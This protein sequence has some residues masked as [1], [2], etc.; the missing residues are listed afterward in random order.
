MREHKAKNGSRIRVYGSYGE[1]MQ[2]CLGP[3]EMP[4]GKRSSRSNEDNWSGGSWAHAEK[5]GPMGDMATA[6]I[7]R[8]SIIKEANRVMG[9]VSR[10]DP[11]YREE[12]GVW[13]DVSRFLAGEPEVWGDMVDQ[14]ATRRARRAAIVF[15][16]CANC[17]VSST[18][19]EKVARLIGGA[20]LGLKAMGI[21]VSLHVCYANRG[22]VDVDITAIDMTPGEGFDVA[23]LAA[24]TSTWFFR[25]LVFSLWECRDAAYRNGHGI[26]GFYGSS[27]PMTQQ[28]AQELTGYKGATVLNLE[29]MTVW[30]EKQIQEAILS[31]I[32]QGE[33]VL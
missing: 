20:I 12:G 7:L 23:R 2:T 10:F 11:V 31:T 26:P 22:G 6:K 30:P 33:A 28:D 25:R 29:Q 21:S 3:S 13:I 24:T 5:T 27:I 18:N 8:S 15:N 14:G 4:L 17:M 9:Q 16:A 19:Y 32:K 1:F